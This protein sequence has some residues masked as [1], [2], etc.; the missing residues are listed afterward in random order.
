[1][2]KFLTLSQAWH[3]IAAIYRGRYLAMKDE[4]AYWKSIATRGEK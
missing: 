4:A 3:M 1:M 2:K